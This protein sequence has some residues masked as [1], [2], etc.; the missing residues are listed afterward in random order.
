EYTIEGESVSVGGS[1]FFKDVN[2]QKYIITI[3]LL[4]GGMMVAQ[5]MGGA[6]AGIAKNIAT[7]KMGPTPM[8][9][10]RE[11]MEAFQGKREARRKQKVADFGE[12]MYGVYNR[13]VSGPG[14]AWN[15]IKGGAR[16]LWS[17]PEKVQE[18][19]RKTAEKVAEKQAKTDHQQ[20]LLEAHETGVY[21][22]GGVEYTYNSSAN[23]YIDKDGKV[24]KDHKDNE[25]GR[26]S[27]I[28]AGMLTGW[29]RGMAEAHGVQNEITNKKIGEKQKNFEAAGLSTTELQ[30][31]LGDD[32]A[33]RDEKLA[34][35]ITLAIKEGY[36]NADQMNVA[37]QAIGTNA[38]LLKQFNDTV[39]KKFAHL[40]YA[41]KNASG[42]YEIDSAGKEKIKE[43]MD[44]GV[45]DGTN[46][47]ASA[48]G[49]ADMMMTLKDYY[50]DDFKPKM[51]TASK[52]N[53]A[54]KNSI[55]TG[56]IKARNKEGKPLL[57][58]NGELNS[59][60]SLVGRLGDVMAG[61]NNYKDSTGKYS[62]EKIDINNNDSI[63]AMGQFFE[64]AK[65][66]HLD[67]FDNDNLKFDK[68]EDK[69]KQLGMGRTDAENIV[70]SIEQAIADGVSDNRLVGMQKAGFSPE[71]IKRSIGIIKDRDGTYKHEVETNNIL[72]NIKHIDPDSV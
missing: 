34:A 50:G 71:F 31:I 28:K 38:P 10:A 35:A 36:E 29:N 39:D 16:G 64:L 61:F 56:A 65:S 12:G 66:S 22:K 46:M 17:T 72:K 20:A 33:S 63:K 30:K 3:A 4:I 68:V 58:A 1:E 25:L 5:Q 27:D 51:E 49:N 62:D 14:A 19:K 43:R 21:K 23:R 40:N 48:Y 6:A 52:R 32:S 59:Y 37:K 70:K 41:T 67:N 2:F 13:A 54:V 45:I 53:K 7:G 24:A 44:E 26:M 18:T 69:I 60:A 55:K 11:R 8:R 57:D 15:S 42:E 9:W 47:D